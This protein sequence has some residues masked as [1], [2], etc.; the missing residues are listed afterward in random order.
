VGICITISWSR[1]LD[2]NITTPYALLSILILS[3]LFNPAVSSLQIFCLT[4]CMH[5]HPPHICHMTGYLRLLDLSTLEI[6]G[7]EYKLLNSG[8]MKMTESLHEI[9][10]LLNLRFSLW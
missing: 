5:S 6:F 9:L 2:K 1:T 3:S 8:P 4:S 10:M 7:E